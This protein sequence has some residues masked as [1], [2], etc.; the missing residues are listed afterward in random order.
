MN[1]KI[2]VAAVVALVALVGIMYFVSSDNEFEA[3]ESQDETADT[4]ENTNGVEGN[5]DSD[6]GAV[7]AKN[8]VTLAPAETGKKVV[9]SSATL[10]KPG[11]VVIYRVNSNNDTSVLGNSA[12]LSA[13]T[14]SNLSIE[15]DSIIA[16][17]QTIVAVLHEDDGDGE[18]EFPGSD[19]YLGSSERP[20]VTDVDVVDIAAENEDVQLRE[21]VEL[22]L[23]A[24]LDA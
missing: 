11:Y 23:E 15:L 5:T 6:T 21:N 19:G 22:F 13:G 8:D 24:N 10:T 2:V 3:M 4:N 12:L 18:F 9:V 17:E 16:R 20:V 7:T 14:Y 1:N